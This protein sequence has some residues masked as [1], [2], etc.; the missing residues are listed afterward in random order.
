MRWLISKVTILV[1]HSGYIHVCKSVADVK[2][3]E[4]EK[5][6]IYLTERVI[7]NFDFMDLS[8]RCVTRIKF[9]EKQSVFHRYS[10]C[11]E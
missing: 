8:C 1:L 11:N 2:I 10:M 3:Y 4:E 7:D 9:R 5:R 6:I